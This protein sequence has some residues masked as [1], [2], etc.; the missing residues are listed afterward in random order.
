MTVKRKTHSAQFE[1]KVAPAAIEGDRTIDDLAGE[2][3]VHPT[4]IHAWKKLLLDAP[5]EI[6]ASGKKCPA[7]PVEDRQTELYEQT[8]RLEMG[9]EWLQKKVGPA[10]SN[11]GGRRSSRATR[12]CRSGGS[13]S[14]RV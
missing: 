8:G 4:M 3:Q 13:A 1:A 9:L 6:F 7:A 12:V 5:E 11:A 14:S 10:R 2:F